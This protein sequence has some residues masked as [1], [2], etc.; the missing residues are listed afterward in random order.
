MVNRQMP[1]SQPGTS[2]LQWKRPRSSPATI[3]CMNRTSEK[4]LNPSGGFLPPGRMRSRRR[5][6][7]SA[8]NET[9]MTNCEIRPKARDGDRAGCC[10][11][12]GSRGDHE[13]A[14]LEVSR[15]WHPLLYHFRGSEV[16]PHMTLDQRRSATSQSRSITQARSKTPRAKRDKSAANAWPVSHRALYDCQSDG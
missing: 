1:C 11:Q 4:A 6:G 9:I 13:Q 7:S 12:C 2:S 16:V 3:Q 5:S 15:D 10:E 8:T 14:C